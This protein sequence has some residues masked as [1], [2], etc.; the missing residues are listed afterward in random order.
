MAADS[1]GTAGWVGAGTAPPPQDVGY[2]R[3]LVDPRAFNKPDKFSGEKTDWRD[4]VYAFRTYCAAVHPRMKEVM[5]QAMAGIDIPTPDLQTEEVKELG[6]QLALMLTMLM[7]GDALEI[8]MEV[9]EGHGF[10]MWKRLCTHYEVNRGGGN[11]LHKLTDPVAN[12]KGST[13]L[14]RISA[15]KRYAAEYQK[16]SGD[17]VSQAVRISAIMKLAPPEMKLHLALNRDKFKTQQEL[18]DVILNYTM[19]EEDLE[20][21]KMDVGA[22][23][24]EDKTIGGMLDYGGKDSWYKG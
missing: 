10:E 16:R 14:L 2:S 21:S 20:D 7:K 18:E 17:I 6:S 3:T 15:Y 8:G 12:F 1:A 11:M 4:W 24:P 5:V 13:V 19:A 22:V 23:I 9:P